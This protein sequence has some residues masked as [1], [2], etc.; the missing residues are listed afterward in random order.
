MLT[1][2]LGSQNDIISYPKEEAEGVTHNII[3]IFRASGM[4]TQQAFDEAGKMLCQ[5][6]RDWI[7]AIANLPT[8]DGEVETEASQ[9][10]VTAC[11]A[12]ISANLHWQ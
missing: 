1:T 10:Y 8:C 5:C 7:L 11:K 3:T 2:H 12:T 9:K 6:E 4:T